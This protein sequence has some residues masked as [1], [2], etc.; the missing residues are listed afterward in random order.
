[1]R[2]GLNGTD[3][4]LG[5]WSQALGKS[6]GR[7]VGGGDAGVGDGRL[8][9]L[10]LKRERAHELASDAARLRALLAAT[11]AADDG[12]KRIRGRVQSVSG[13][14]AI[15]TGGQKVALGAAD[16]IPGL[17]PGTV[18][19]GSG[20]A[21]GGGLFVASKLGAVGVGLKA[22][23]EQ[24]EFQLQVAPVQNFAVGNDE[25][26]FD[27][28]R[29]FLWSGVQRFERGMRLGA[30]R[31]GCTAKDDYALHVSLEWG[32][33]NKPNSR[34]LGVLRGTLGFESPLHVPDDVP[35]GVR[36]KVSLFGLD[37]ETPKD[38]TICDN[39]Q[40]I[41]SRSTPAVGA[42]RRLLRQGQVQPEA[43]SGR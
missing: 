25:I 26:V 19:Q 4:A 1:M 22:A 24:C 11:C 14:L 13:D 21:L 23:L 38:I 7:A 8:A 27:D 35:A 39:A 37:C 36:L 32:P 41:Y 12:T 17:A 2:R 31:S 34:Y 15:L 3:A 28:A 42:A 6:W 5:R 20:R 9:G 10:L 30:S 29:A 18:V 33:K 40:L 43:V 16:A